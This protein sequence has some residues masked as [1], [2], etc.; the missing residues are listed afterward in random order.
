MRDYVENR[1][2]SDQYLPEV[3]RIVADHILTEAPDPLDWHEATDLVN[4][5]VRLKHVAVRVRRPGYADRF[6]YDFT[7]RS[8]LASGG[9]TELTKIVNGHGDWMFYGHAGED[10]R[11]SRW[12]LLDLRAFRSALIRRQPIKTGERENSDGSCFRWFDVRSF[13]SSPRLVV[14]ASQ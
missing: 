12:W 13:P 4:M 10:G 14:S 11:L 1:R 7:V 3:K 9:Q 6:P 8:R 2:W 5:D